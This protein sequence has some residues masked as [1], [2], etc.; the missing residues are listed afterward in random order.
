M[1]LYFTLTDGIKD[2]EV[3]LNMLRLCLK[4][5]K[6]NT[7]LKL[8]ALYDGQKDDNVYKIFEENNV[9]IIIT[10]CSFENKL[11]NYYSDYKFNGIRGSLKRMLGCFM[12]F[13]IV[14]YEK[15]DDVILYADIDTMFLND[16][17]ESLLKEIK[18]IG[19]A[20]ETNFEYDNIKG[21]KYFS[22][23]IMAI[24]VKEGLKRREILFNMLENK[25]EPYQECWDQGFWNELYKDDFEKL[26]LE[27]NWKPYW[28]INDNAIIIHIHGLK[29]GVTNPDKID[30]GL[31]KILQIIFEGAFEGWIYYTLKAYRI[32]GID[33]DRYVADFA[34]YLLSARMEREKN[35]KFSTF[36]LHYI[37][38]KYKDKHQNFIIKK[39]YQYSKTKLLQRNV[40]IDTNKLFK[41]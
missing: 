17:D 36:F 32:L 27:Y 39:L 41:R 40:I 37:Y 23:G 21:Y 16:I 19:V 33:K 8:Y 18:T 14:L 4:S 7:S 10:S 11:K 29:L 35:W 6:E 38:S 2:D 31:C 15:E 1:K 13:D 20:P 26:P 5:A 30:F 25:Q 9:N 34:K 24:N 12:K 3:N 28:G 22:A